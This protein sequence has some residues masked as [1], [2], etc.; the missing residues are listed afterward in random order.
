MDEHMSLYKKL[1]VCF[2]IQLM[3]NLL[4]LLVCLFDCR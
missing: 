4:S 3:N 2:V 1:K